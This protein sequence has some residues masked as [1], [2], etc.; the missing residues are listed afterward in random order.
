MPLEHAGAAAPTLA[1]GAL[2]LGVE[3]DAAV[4]ERLERYL[5]LLQRW[6]KVYNLTAVRDPSE[7]VSHHLLDSLA[8][9]API[10]REL[11]ASGRPIDDA[12]LL[13]VGSGAGLP[14]A[15]LAAVWPALKVTC[16]D[17]VAKK[18]GFIRQVA[19]ECGML[20]LQAVH[21]RAQDVKAAP[22]DVITSRAL[23]PVDELVAMTERLLTQGG[24]WAAMKGKRPTDEFDKL[25][26]TVE[27]FHVEPLTVPGL[28]AE[29]CIVWMRRRS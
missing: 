29:R 4:L 28:G 20:N 3:L 24:V 1:A 14:G 22:F 15:V 11:A 23:G 26:P 9:A 6:N 25:P 16:V 18:A 2:R 17:A 12:R 10:A 27:V 7:M 19:A 8:V 13:D 21:A 5:A